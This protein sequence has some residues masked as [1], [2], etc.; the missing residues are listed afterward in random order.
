MIAK[1]PPSK[2]PQL[3]KCS[4]PLTKVTTENNALFGGRRV[5]GAKHPF[6]PF[7][8]FNDGPP[9]LTPL[10][11]HPKIGSTDQ[12]ASICSLNSKNQ[13][14]VDHYAYKDRVSKTS[15]S[16]D[17]LRC[18]TPPSSTSHGNPPQILQL[19][20]VLSSAIKLTQ[21]SRKEDLSTP[22][23]QEEQRIEID[24]DP[25]DVLTQSPPPSPIRARK[26]RQRNK[27]KKQNS[28]WGPHEE[29]TTKNNDELQKII[30]EQQNEIKKLKD[31]FFEEKRLYEES[32]G[33]NGELLDTLYKSAEYVAKKV[34]PSNRKSRVSED[35]ISSDSSED[36]NNKKKT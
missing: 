10:N 21:Q 15:L 26:M 23:S 1:E 34:N 29:L 28:L 36:T 14:E 7:T 35:D 12:I 3:K 13:D 11:K 25:E 8:D 19:S 17:I 16:N 4:I 2:Y 33:G 18:D 30:K 24:F 32:R 31:H 22:S 27:G 9:C 20:E 5:A 6:V